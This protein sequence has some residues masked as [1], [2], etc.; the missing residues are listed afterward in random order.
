M[1]SEKITQVSTVFVILRCM[2]KEEDRELWR[3]C[4]TSIRYFYESA[5]IVIIDDNS[6]IEDEFDSRV[7]NTTILKSDFA[8]ASEVLPFYYFLKHHWADTMLIFHDAM[9]LKRPF[10][11][12]EL[13]DTVKFFWDFSDHQTDDDAKIEEL[14][15]F[16][17][18]SQ[19]LK[20][21]NKEKNAWN[22]WFGLA[23]I[24]N[25]SLL[26]ALDDKYGIAS[27]LVNF[28]KTRDDRMAYERIVALALF[29][30]Q[31]VTQTNCSAFGSIHNYPG[32]WQAGFEWQMANKHLYP[33]AVM[34]TWA[35]R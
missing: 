15:K 14:L 25:W 9:F 27:L 17:P 24:I 3:R 18:E 31:L 8:G 2:R 21:L 35:G 30:E 5:N 34:K 13:T 26:K 12:S 28:V 10:K 33:Y 4:Y 19:A 29:N 32:S 16:I 22:G 23:G 6:T 7:L 11:T 1:N 20:A